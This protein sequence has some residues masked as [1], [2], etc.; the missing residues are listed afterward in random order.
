MD[1]H[2][3]GTPVAGRL[4]Q[5]TRTTTRKRAWP[6]AKRRPAV[7]IRSCS[8]WGLQCQSR[9]R[10]RGA[11]LPHPFTLT[12]G[13]EDAP[14]VCFLLHFPWGRP[15]RALPGTVF[16]WSPDFP[17]PPSEDSERGHPTVWRPLHN[18][19]RPVNQSGES[20]NRTNRTNPPN[21]AAH[22]ASATPSIR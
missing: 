17:P 14:A 12:D 4:A 2:S 8:R 3:S 20:I 21:S 7:P 16:P 1:D 18:R 9:R 10:D 6:H 11:L 5:P 22:S 13:S 19:A 15:R